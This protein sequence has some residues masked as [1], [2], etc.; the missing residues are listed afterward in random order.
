[1]RYPKKILDSTSTA[2]NIVEN[3]TKFMKDATLEKPLESK[4]FDQIM[5]EMMA[6]RKDVLDDET[7]SSNQ[8]LPVIKVNKLIPIE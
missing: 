5:L 6:L 3:V 8:S 2:G 7:E 4:D 1:M